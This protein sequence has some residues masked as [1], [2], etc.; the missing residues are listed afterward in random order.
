MT[1]PTPYLHFDGAAADALAFYAEVFG[2]EAEL[3]TFGDFGRTDGSA[4][5]IAHGILRGPVSLFA[6]DVAGHEPAVKIEGVLFSLLGTADTDTLARWFAGLAE[7]GEIVDALQK[8][9]W[10]AHDGVVTDRFGIRWLIGYE[11]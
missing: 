10:G 5:R 7:E 1:A 8:R 6:A 4:E 2:G 11:D 3:H 9:P